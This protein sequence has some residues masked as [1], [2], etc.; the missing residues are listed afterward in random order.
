MA[1][2]HVTS[3]TIPLALAFAVAAH[4]LP[5]AADGNS[6][7]VFDNAATAIGCNDAKTAKTTDSLSAQKA[8]NAAQNAKEELCVWER[9]SRDHNDYAYILGNATPADMATAIF[10]QS[11]YQ[12]SGKYTQWERARTLQAYHAIK[13]DPEIRYNAMLMDQ[14]GMTR[15]GYIETMQKVTNLVREAFGL[16]PTVRVVEKRL[17]PESTVIAQYSPEDDNIQVN[18][19]SN[20]SPTNDYTQMLL[21]VLEEAKHS[22]DFT[23][24]RMMHD[25]IIG[26]NDV[27]ASHAAAIWLNE[28]TY[29]NVNE[30]YTD[31]LPAGT[32]RGYDA[33]CY[34]YIERNA[35]DFALNVSDMLLNGVSS[36]APALNGL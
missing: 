13:N 21:I 35:K 22:V 6:F 33:Y 24:A 29:A 3:L 26:R 10:M 36:A 23:F 25:G 2:K 9:Y 18:L 5:A 8:F 31:Q 20:E 15:A 14:G 19:N 11:Q 27:R 1:Q 4:S 32:L 16:L 34:Q 17:P 30:S 7:S 28:R 12:P